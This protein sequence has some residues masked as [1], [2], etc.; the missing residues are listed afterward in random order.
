M[1]AP[2]HD[3]LEAGLSVGGLAL[4]ELAHI[5]VSARY[6]NSDRRERTEIQRTLK[7]TTPTGRFSSSSRENQAAGRATATSLFPSGSRR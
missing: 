2:Q 7:R 3:A 6:L 1:G 4:P 5:T